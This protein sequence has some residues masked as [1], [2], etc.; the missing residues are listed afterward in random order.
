VADT[1]ATFDGLRAVGAAGVSVDGA[2]CD[3]VGRGRRCPR[4]ARATREWALVTENGA[5]VITLVP[6]QGGAIAVGFDDV[7]LQTSLVIAAGH[8]RRALER[9]RVARTKDPSADGAVV[10]RAFF[11]PVDGPRVALFERAVA[12]Q[13]RVEPQRADA[14]TRLVHDR[15]S[16]ATEGFVADVVDTSR[17]SGQRGT[18]TLT[19]SAAIDGMEVGVDVFVPGVVTP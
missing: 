13:F 7:T 11:A 9:A 6:P 12:P 10:V 5:D 15:P 14:V 2:P 19:V 1:P 8:T 4:G 17:V 16:W 3:I 18:L